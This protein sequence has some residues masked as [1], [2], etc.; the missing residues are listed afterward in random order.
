VKCRLSKDGERCCLCVKAKRGCTW[1]KVGINPPS[2]K[3][4]QVEPMADNNNELGKIDPLAA[5]GAV[6]DDS[7]RGMGMRS[8]E[9]AKGKKQ[10]MDSEEEAMPKKTHFANK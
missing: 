7:S 1:I 3:T 10:K 8:S 4:V 6:D 9:G 5:N 2:S